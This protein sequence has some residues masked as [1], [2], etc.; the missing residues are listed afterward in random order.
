MLFSTSTL[1]NPSITRTKASNPTATL[2]AS[3]EPETEDEI[4]CWIL[5]T[6]G[7]PKG[8]GPA[9]KPLNQSFEWKADILNNS[10]HRAESPAKLP[11]LVTSTTSYPQVQTIPSQVHQNWVNELPTEIKLP[12]ESDWVREVGAH[13]S[14]ATISSR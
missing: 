11:D 2:F 7:Q 3:C 5:S 13:R 1:H 8:Q 14:S 10:C 4:L 9:I 6:A 12:E